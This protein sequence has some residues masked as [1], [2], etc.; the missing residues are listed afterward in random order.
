[1]MEMTLLKMHLEMELV[2]ITDSDKLE[3]KKM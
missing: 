3:F 1:M 2:A